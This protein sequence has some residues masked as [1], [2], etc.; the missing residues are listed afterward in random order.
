MFDNSKLPEHVKGKVADWINHGK[1]N[2]TWSA[3]RTAEC[4]AKQCQKESKLNFD[5][6]MTAEDTLTFIYWLIEVRGLKVSTANSYLAG[7]RQLH[8]MKGLPVPKLHSE[9]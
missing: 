3:Y 9:L 2:K 5:W 8:I 6:P 4:M 1:T 7:L